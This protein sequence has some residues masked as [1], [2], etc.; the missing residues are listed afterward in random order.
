[1]SLKIG[2]IIDTY[3]ILIKKGTVMQYIL[4]KKKTEFTH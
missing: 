3:L 4:L 2:I 1:M